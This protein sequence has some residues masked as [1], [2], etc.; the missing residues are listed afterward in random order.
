MTTYLLYDD[1]LRSPE[2]RHEVGEAVMDPIVFMDRDGVRIVV[3]S[4]LDE[5]IFTAR[6]DVVDEFWINHDLGSEEL[7]KDESVPLELIGPEIVLRALKRAGATAVVVP[8][9][10]PL[11]VA[12]HLRTAGVEV[13]V[14]D[15]AWA[16][17]RRRKAP[18]E[19]EGIERAQRATEAAMLAAAR[20][21]RAA[22]PI[23]TERLRFEGEVLTAELI[24]EAMQAEL[25]AMGAEA[26]EILVHSGDACLRGHDIGRGPIKQ[27]A[28]CIV[29]CYPRDRRTGCYTDMTRTFV[30][31]RPSDDLRALHTHVRA[32][33]E[34][35]FEH[36]KPGRD[37][38]HRAVSAYFHEHGFP[39]REHHSGPGPLREG[40][41]HALGHGVGLEVHERPWLSRRHDV[42]AV[43]DV[44]AVEPGL[45]FE[46]VG[47]VRLED[48][49]V[50]TE[51]GIEHLTD[52]HP[53]SLEP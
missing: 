5:D 9:T 48:T 15:E 49:V 32:A 44:L 10:F 35:A 27:D 22:E 26:E 18:W 47:G 19:I 31:G 51:D 1:A 42:I 20:M 50:I 37:D 41:F 7:I 46:G 14:D 12:D 29:D 43:G 13:T 33:L 34:I 21:L 52:P 2:L 4:V 38:A 6:E 36:L 24:R 28:S 11:L 30:A 39:T 23:G 25:A 16:S 3:G 53:Y 40:F 8:A 45:Y 17:R